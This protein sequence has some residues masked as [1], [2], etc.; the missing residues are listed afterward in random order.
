MNGNCTMETKVTSIN[1]WFHCRLFVNGKLFHE[2]ACER[3][4]DIGSLC[5]QM[6]YDADKYSGWWNQHTL[7]LRERM[8]KEGW[9]KFNG[10]VKM[11]NDH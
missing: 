11:C 5:R 1:G 6:M 4:D 3:R 9:P 10:R 2:M 8:I 7:A